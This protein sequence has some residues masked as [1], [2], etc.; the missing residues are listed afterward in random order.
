[1][2]AYKRKPRIKKSTVWDEMKEVIL[3]NGTK[4]IQCNYCNELFAKS[5]INTTTQCNPRLKNCLQ[6][7]LKLEEQN[8]QKHVL[9]F[10]E[11]QA[12]GISSIVNLSYDYAKCG[13]MH[14]IQ[15]L[16]MFFHLNDGTCHS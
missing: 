5:F 11:M 1:M 4:K 13:N 14:L 12:G 7:K 2:V 10:I 3:N 15:F 9:Y 6:K 8:R 16:V